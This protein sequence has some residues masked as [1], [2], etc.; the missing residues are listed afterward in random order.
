MTLSINI[1]TISSNVIRDR[2]RQW[3]NYLVRRHRETRGSTA[4]ALIFTVETMRR[5]VE[6]R[7]LPRR[8]A[9]KNMIMFCIGTVLLTS[10]VFAILNNSCL[11]GMPGSAV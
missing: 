11:Y 2:Y 8:V 6:G 4:N 9:E 3:L 10:W 1:V 5:A 7:W